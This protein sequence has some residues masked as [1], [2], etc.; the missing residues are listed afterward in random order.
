ML[1]DVTPGACPGFFIGA[2]PKGRKS[3]PRADSGGGVLGAVAASQLRDL[4][5]WAAP[6]F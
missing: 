6:P 3:R 1:S 2:R 4:G 5:A